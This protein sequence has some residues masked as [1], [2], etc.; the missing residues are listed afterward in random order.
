VLLLVF[1]AGCSTEVLQMGPNGDARIRTL[2]IRGAQL[3]PPFSPTQQK[4]SVL[5]ADPATAQIKVAPYRYFTKFTVNERSMVMRTNL[6]GLPDFTP[7]DLAGQS[8]IRIA[9]VAEDGLQRLYTVTLLDREQVDAGITSMSVDGG[10]FSPSFSE[11]GAPDYISYRTKTETNVYTLAITST[12]YTL[13]LVKYA[14]NAS[15]TVNGTAVAAGAVAGSIALQHPGTEAQQVVRV[16]N[17]S[18]DGS[19]TNV[20]TLNVLYQDPATD[21]RALRVTIYNNSSGVEVPYLPKYDFSRTEYTLVLDNFSAI[22]MD[23]TAA[24]SGAA[25]QI[26]QSSIDSTGAYGIENRYTNNQPI[27]CQMGDRIT[28]EVRQ[29]TTV[30]NYV[31]EVTLFTRVPYDFRGGIADFLRFIH[32]EKEYGS[33]QYITVTGIVTF[34]VASSDGFFIEDAEYGLYVWAGWYSK[35]AGLREGQKVTIQFKY[36]KLWLGM[37]EVAYSSAWQPNQV[38]QTLV[39]RK[40]RPLYYQDSAATS[41]N[42]LA[43]RTLQIYRHAGRMFRFKTQHPL[44]GGFNSGWTGQFDQGHAYQLA[45]DYG[46]VE[47]TRQSSAAVTYMKEGVEGSFFGPLLFEGAMYMFVAHPQFMIIPREHQPD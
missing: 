29:G 6:Y 13:S 15:L 23:V 11:G 10:Q 18:P 14:R 37:A 46:N 19:F 24:Q 41:W 22:R 25:V 47:A 16:T 44:S 4:Y 21:A 40:P 31:W 5:V 36:A 2:E 9:A 20:K 7:I 34:N 42:S 32:Q 3:V 17:I 8:N 43:D 1:S 26:I 28:V 38:K 30:K 39:D 27:A 12:N 45:E 35:P 33:A